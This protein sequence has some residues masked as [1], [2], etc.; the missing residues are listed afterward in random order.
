MDCVI[1]L[2]LRTSQIERRHLIDPASTY[3]R[4]VDDHEYGNKGANTSERS[5]LSPVLFK[6]QLDCR[7]H[8]VK[9]SKE[10]VGKKHKTLSI[11]N[12]II[13]QISI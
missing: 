6:A 5:A 8:D 9:S 4:I 12:L 7:R 3:E 2:L 1:I 13:L 10:V 11:F